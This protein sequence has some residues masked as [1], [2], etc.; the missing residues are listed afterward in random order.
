VGRKCCLIY[1]IYLVFWF[2]IKWSSGNCIID[3]PFNF[4]CPY[5]PLREEL[6]L[7]DVH[8]QALLRLRFLPGQ[9]LRLQQ[10]SKHSFS[11][12]SEQTWHRLSLGKFALLIRT[13]PSLRNGLFFKGSRWKLIPLLESF[14][15]LFEQSPPFCIWWCCLLEICGAQWRHPMRS[16]LQHG[17]QNG[18]RWNCSSG[19]VFA[20]TIRLKGKFTS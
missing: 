20:V 4:L 1:F 13:S 16:S 18:G 6:Y 17:F 10:L 11:K 8:L 2:A 15:V 9:R 3:Q 12:W 14:D 19:E 7:F 5:L